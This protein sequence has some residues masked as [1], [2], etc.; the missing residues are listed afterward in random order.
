MKKTMIAWNARFR[1]RFQYVSFVLLDT[2]LVFTTEFV[3]IWVLKV[4]AREDSKR[5]LRKEIWNGFRRL[6]GDED[7]NRI[8]L[9]RL[10]LRRSEMSEKTRCVLGIQAVLFFFLRSTAIIWQLRQLCLA[11][12]TNRHALPGLHPINYY[13]LLIADSFCQQITP[14][15]M[16]QY[17]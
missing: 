6:V 9:A 1:T 7:E 14:K 4:P 3:D 15:F 16:W 13:S 8:P 17:V 12:P 11:Y 10:K 2:R 5:R